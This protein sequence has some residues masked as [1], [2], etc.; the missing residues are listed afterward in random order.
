VDDFIKNRIFLKIFLRQKLFGDGGN[1]CHNIF[2]NLEYKKISK[3]LE[4][5]FLN[6]SFSKKQ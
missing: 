1:F 6:F 5:Y 4:N 3:I 2:Q